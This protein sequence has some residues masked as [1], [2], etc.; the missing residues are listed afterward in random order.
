MKR[1]FDL[2]L[3]GV[4][5]AIIVLFTSFSVFGEKREFSVDENRALMLMPEISK[6]AVLDGSFQHDYEEY[7]SDQFEWRSTFVKVK[8]DLMLASGRKDFNGVF[9]GKDGYL[10]EKYDKADYDFD[11]VKYNEETLS[12]FLTYAAD[13]YGINTVCSFVPS[14][15]GVLLKELPSMVQTFDSSYIASE[16]LE[17]AKGVKTADLYKTLQSHDGEYI[18]YRTDHHWTS[19]GAYYAYGSLCKPLGI[20]PVSLNKLEANEVSRDFYGSTFDKVQINTEPDVITSYNTGIKVSVNYSDGE[21]AA[22]LYSPE[23]LKEK[24]K[25]DY[26]LGGNFSRIDIST[27]ADSDRTLLLI[28]D[29]YANSIVPFLCCNY[30]NIIML[31]LRF[32]DGDVYELLDEEDID[33]LLVLFNTE[34]FMIDENMDLLEQVSPDAQEFDEDDAFVEE[35]EAEMENGN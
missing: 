9:I 19:L 25:Y 23:M 32:Y 13:E 16:V 4:F 6:D 15:S 31:D 12:D 35:A 7:L 2:A 26:F 14:K 21:R 18:Y 11:T 24:N 27:D 3:I 1:K 20:K 10:I 8:T 5:I 17:Y 34:K 22:S 28:K 33:D 30:S 29:S